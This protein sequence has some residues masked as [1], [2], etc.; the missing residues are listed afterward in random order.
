MKACN[1]SQENPPSSDSIRDDA[2]ARVLGPETRG[3]VRGLG[4]G[5]TPSRVNAAIQG[6]GKVKELE[7]II[8]F[9]AQ[10]LAQVEAKLDAVLNFNQEVQI[11][12]SNTCVLLSNTCV[13]YSAI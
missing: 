5:A 13:S 4:F 2:L 10:R 6:S 11:Y 8:D 3:R 9:Q 7:A 1:E 12:L